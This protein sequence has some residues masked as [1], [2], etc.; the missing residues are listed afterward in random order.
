MLC[1]AGGV[2]TCTVL[3]SAT[4][5]HAIQASPRSLTAT[6]ALALWHGRLVQCSEVT[7]PACCQGQRQPPSLHDTGFWC[8]DV[9]SC[10]M[11]TDHSHFHEWGA[12]LLY[13]LQPKD[14]QRKIIFGLQLNYS[15]YFYG[16]LE[17][18]KLWVG[19]QSITNCQKQLLCCHNSFL[20]L[21]SLQARWFFK[22]GN[23][24]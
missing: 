22:N 8:G 19:F 17:W 16:W 23:P 2:N 20:T 18:N 3:C 5:K 14:I 21:S 4:Y 15:W 7:W 24:K 1:W 12:E 9:P 10:C 13:Y 6:V 11:S